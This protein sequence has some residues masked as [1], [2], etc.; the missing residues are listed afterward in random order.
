MNSNTYYVAVVRFRGMTLRIRG[1]SFVQF[2]DGFWINDEHEYTAQYILAKIQEDT[3]QVIDQSDAK[4]WI[5]PSAIL[6][7]EKVVEEDD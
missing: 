7:I 6:F 2:K 5:P 3:L 1:Y 4:Y